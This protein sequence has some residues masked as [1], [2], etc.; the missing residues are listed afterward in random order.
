MQKVGPFRY[1]VTRN[2]VDPVYDDSLKVVNYTM[3]HDYILTNPTDENTGE[4]LNAT[5]ITTLNLDG[6]SV[7]YQMNA[8]R[9]EFWKAWQSMTL[10]STT[11]TDSEMLSNFYAY[12][13]YEYLFYKSSLVY[14]VVLPDSLFTA[15]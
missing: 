7:W 10:V 15:S 9:P 11:M 3:M 1:N 6:Q 14:E 4:Q 2:F 12:Q 5:E 13:A 8:E